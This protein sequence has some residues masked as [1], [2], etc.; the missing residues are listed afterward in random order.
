MRWWVVATVVLVACGRAG[1]DKVKPG[2]GAD[3]AT[4]EAIPPSVMGLVVAGE[5]DSLVGPVTPDERE[6][7]PASQGAEP[8]RLMLWQLDGKPAKLVVSEPT[9][10]GRMTGES[11]WYFRDGQTV[12]AR[13]PL[14]HFA[15]DAGRLVEWT[16]VRGVVLQ[17]DAKA[18]AEQEKQLK[19]AAARWLKELGK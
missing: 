10:A 6:L 5:I 14:G 8:R 4:A 19:D 3:A 12:Y 7:P 15:Y 11:A 2:A 13:G 9:D 18:L 1:A 17:R 16:D